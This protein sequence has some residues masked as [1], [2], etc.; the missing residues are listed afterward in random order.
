MPEPCSDPWDPRLYAR[1]SAERNQSFADLLALVHRPLAGGGAAQAVDLGCGTGAL[2]RLLFDA[3]QESGQGPLRVLAL[4]N[5]PA[6][7]AASAAY[8]SAGLEFQQAVIECFAYASSAGVG[9]P[10]ASPWPA[11]WDLIFSNAA[12]QYVEDH[13]QLFTALCNKLAPGGQLAVQMPCNDDHPAYQLAAEVAAEPRF[14]QPL[15]G[16]VR[17]SPVQPPQWYAS[18]FFALGLTQVDVHVRV[19]SHVLA[20]PVLVAQ[21]VRGT[22]LNNY[23]KL[24]DEASA[25]DYLAAYERKLGGVLGSTRPYLFT[26]KRVFIYGVQPG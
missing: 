24:L 5:S 12:L 13:A 11:R 19:Y 10:A 18:L 1:F 15:G 8:A 7:L 14:A 4:D 6:M 23:T 20:E 25:A 9:A 22:L 21:W 16:Y 2:T 17:R 26:F 3:L